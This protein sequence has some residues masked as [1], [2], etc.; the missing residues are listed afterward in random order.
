MR[1]HVTGNAGS[2]KSTFASNVG[3]ILGINVYSLDK[4]VWQS[5]WRKTP[6][7]ERTILEGQLVAKDQWIIEGVSTIVRQAADIIVLLDL[8]RSACYARCAT[9]NWRYLFSSRPGL[10]DNC[11]EIRII[12]KLIRIIWRFPAMVRPAIVQD[13]DLKLAVTLSSQ[14]EMNDFLIRLRSDRQTAPSRNC[15]DSFEHYV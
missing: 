5:R 10:P 12:P 1:I 15:Y 9:R 7:E 11:P 4:V 3:D 13:S 14:D 8:P 2:G 6:S